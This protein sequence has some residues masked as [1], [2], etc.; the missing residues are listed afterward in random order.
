MMMMDDVKMYNNDTNIM[1]SDLKGTFHGADHKILFKHMRELG[2]PS[3]FITTCGQLY[4]VSNTNY[5]TPH[6]NTPHIDINRGTVQGDTLPPFLFTLFLEPFLRWPTLGSRGYIPGPIPAN[7]PDHSPTEAYP[8]HGFADSLSFKTCSIHNLTIQLNKLSLFSEHMG[9]GVNAKNSYMAVQFRAVATNAI[10]KTTKHSLNTASH[11]SSSKSI[12]CPSHSQLS[13]P[14][15][16][17]KH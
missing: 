5:I 10:S 14:L 1:Y 2:M 9:L 4:G 12:G 3:S 7:H 6:G 16:I 17:T 13:P 15:K 11:I 8:D